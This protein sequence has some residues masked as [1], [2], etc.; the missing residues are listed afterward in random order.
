[1]SKEENL[2]CNNNKINLISKDTIVRVVKDVVNS[3][4]YYIE[5][6]T[7]RN[8][9]DKIL[10]FLSDY[11]KLEVVI[12]FKNNDKQVLNFFVKAVPQANSTKA[13]FV[14]EMKF[15]EKEIVFYSEICETIRIKGK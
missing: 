2:I 13:N 14:K 11:L 9:S 12:S 15:L 6:Y 1:M 4:D 8:P 5:S 7:E 10:G 3:N